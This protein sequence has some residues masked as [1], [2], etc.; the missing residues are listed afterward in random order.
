M[1]RLLIRNQ[2]HVR[3]TRK[4]AIVDEGLIFLAGTFGSHT[5]QLI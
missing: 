2:R 5:H 3:K 1:I 4:M